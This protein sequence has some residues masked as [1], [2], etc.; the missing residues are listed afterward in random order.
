MEMVKPTKTW[1]THQILWSS[2]R[3][4]RQNNE[5]NEIMDKLATSLIK[6]PYTAPPPAYYIEYN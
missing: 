4:E 5:N 2:Y 6:T 3:Q 1:Q